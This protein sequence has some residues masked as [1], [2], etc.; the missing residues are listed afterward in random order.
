V[1]SQ[2]AAATDRQQAEQICKKNP[3]CTDYH[4][5]QFSVGGNLVNCPPKGACSIVGG[6]KRVAP[7]ASN[8]AVGILSNTSESSSPDHK[9]PIVPDLRA[10]TSAVSSQGLVTNRT[11][12]GGAGT[13]SYGSGGGNA[14]SS[15]G[16][17]TIGA[18]RATLN[19][20]R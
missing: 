10:N 4:D 5:G 19:K 11:Q 9:G 13:L 20:S 7:I 1:I 2:P 8:R 14:L 3:K 16:S 12:A 6:P 18:T 17:L 15:G